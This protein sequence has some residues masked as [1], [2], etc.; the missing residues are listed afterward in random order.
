MVYLS[1]HPDS[2]ELLEQTEPFPVGV[3][4]N[5][6]RITESNDVEDYFEENIAASDKKVR[7]HTALRTNWLFRTIVVLASFNWYQNL[8]SPTSRILIIWPGNRKEEVAGSFG[9]ILDWNDEAR[10]RF[11][12]IVSGSTHQI[13]EGKFYPSTYIVARGARPDEVAALIL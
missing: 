4:P 11:L 6:K 3:N 9:D 8:A 1:L 10:E 2:Y 12:D 5:L 13:A 7:R